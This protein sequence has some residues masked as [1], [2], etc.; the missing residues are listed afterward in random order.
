MFRD[1]IVLLRENAQRTVHRGGHD[2]RGVRAK[3]DV[4]RSGL[5][6]LK[7]VD[8]LPRLDLKHLHDVGSSSQI[9]A[10]RVEANGRN[11]QMRQ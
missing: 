1:L 7:R 5:V 11:L 8:D 10:G 9:R 4:G 3:L 2:K 6:V